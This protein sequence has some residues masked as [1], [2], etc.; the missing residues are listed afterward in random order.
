[1]YTYFAQIYD[2]LMQDV[3]REK[4][5]LR[6][7]EWI[8]A[9]GISKPFLSES[10]IDNISSE[11]NL[12][13][14]LGCG[15]GTLTEKLAQLGYDMIGIDN[16]PEMLSI[17]MDKKAEAGSGTLYLNQNMQ[18]MDLYSTVGTIIC[19]CDSLNYLLSE[20]DVLKTFKLVKNYLYPGG[21]FIFDFNTVYKYEKVIGDSTI[22][23][24]YEDCAF[25][26]ENNYDS[27]S[28][29]N[30]YDLTLFIKDEDFI[31]AEDVIVNKE[32]NADKDGHF[33]RYHETHF[34]K[35]YELRQ[36]QDL[37]EA[38]GL[39]FVIAID[40]ESEGY[41]GEESERIFVVARKGEKHA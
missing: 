37:L 14:D 6:I 11:K 26:W 40:D 35:G 18:E 15:T 34:Q 24:N 36:I 23:E 29:I 12:V 3:P 30:E 5:S 28:R 38:A 19:I 20:E 1:M 32:F 31:E 17:A 25:I 39:E 10:S 8:E 21:I 4:W 13:V 27:E 2:K 22:A 41:P 7:S 16:S 33:V 9:Y